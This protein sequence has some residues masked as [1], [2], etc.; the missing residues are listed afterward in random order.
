MVEQAS[1]GAPSGKPH[2]PK[3]LITNSENTPARVILKQEMFL[4]TFQKLF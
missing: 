1:R 4:V 2:T 3:A